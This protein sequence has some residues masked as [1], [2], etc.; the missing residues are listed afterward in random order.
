MKY[1]VYIIIGII[2]FLIIRKIIGRIFPK[3]KSANSIIS[4]ILAIGLAPII[5]KVIFILFFNLIMY[6]Y[7]P[8]RK[9]KIDSWQENIQDRHQ[10]S[11]DLIES[12]ILI[13]KTKNQ[14]ATELG[15]PNGEIHL[16]TDTLSNWRYNMGSRGWGFGWKFYYLNIE[17]ENNKTKHVKIEEIID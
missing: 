6:E 4:G 13:N 16:E 17:F 2:L 12:Q 8:N 1:L 11:D 3:L 5:A 10:M 7:H 15:M 9:F 14:I